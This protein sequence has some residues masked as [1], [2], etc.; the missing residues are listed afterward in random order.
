MSVE[1]KVKRAKRTSEIC[2]FT[3]GR[4]RKKGL[5]I[6]GVRSFTCGVAA[7]APRGER[8]RMVPR[9]RP[10]A[11]T[12]CNAVRGQVDD[13]RG[14]CAC[15]SPYELM[16]QAAAGIKSIKRGAFNRR[17]NRAGALLPFFACPLTYISRYPVEI[18]ASAFVLYFAGPFGL[19]LPRPF[20][21]LASG[22]E[23]GRFLVL[24]PFYQ[25]HYPLLYGM[26]HVV[27]E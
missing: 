13:E 10:S 1:S 22:K 26:S 14:L 5:K 21:F 2:A 11:Y 4:Q 6:I 12:F 23:H 16:R 17:S 8:T 3:K 25:P 19:D 20:L 15:S 24:L 27:K 18:L 7:T 9:A